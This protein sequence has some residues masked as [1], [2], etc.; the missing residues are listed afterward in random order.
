M[1]RRRAGRSSRR[2]SDES[3]QSTT[4]STPWS[5][6]ST[7]VRSPPRMRPI[8]TV[9]E[10]RRPRAIPRCPDHGQGEHRPARQPDHAGRAR[11][12]RGPPHRRCARDRSNEGSGRHPDRTH[13]PSRLR[14]ACPHRLVAPRPHPQPTS[15]RS[16]GGR[17]ERRRGRRDRNRH[18]PARARQRHR[19]LAAQPGPLL[20]HRIDQ[21]LGRR[22][23][24]CLV[25]PARGPDVVVPADGGARGRWRA[26]S[27][28]SVPRSESSPA[29]TSATRSA[30]PSR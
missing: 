26:G 20:R 13:E 17:F 2:T 14:P 7:R 12:R 25:A 23:R 1:G 27:P 15:S 6:D 18:E 19:R 22:R 28:T 10:G 5:A 4:R 8:A 24:P 9:A 30:C 3:T 29:P 11:I 16:N 21:A